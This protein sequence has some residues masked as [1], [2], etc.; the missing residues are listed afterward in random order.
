MREAGV[1]WSQGTLSRVENGDRPLRF[2]EADALAAALDTTPDLV[3]IHTEGIASTLLERLGDE[4]NGLDE[5]ISEYEAERQQWVDAHE[6]VASIQALAE[7]AD[8]PNVS[9]AGLGLSDGDASDPF[10]PNAVAL[11]TKVRMFE[12]VELLRY[13]GATDDDLAGITP[14]AFANS[15]KARGQNADEEWLRESVSPLLQRLRADRLPPD[16]KRRRKGSNRG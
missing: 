5:L 15:P 10:R 3:G 6:V 7:G 16:R 14:P 8:L 1:N 12:V 4:A 9:I 11:L 2:S 13:A